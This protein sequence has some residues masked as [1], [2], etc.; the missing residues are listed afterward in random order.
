M[1]QKMWREAGWTKPMLDP[2]LLGHS[3][4]P[5]EA[6][7]RKNGPGCVRPAS[8]LTLHLHLFKAKI[9]E[10]SFDHGLTQNRIPYLGPNPQ[11]IPRFTLDI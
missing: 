5:W 8:H 9:C 2:R 1:K 10:F 6:S 4:V 3:S 7:H 11:S